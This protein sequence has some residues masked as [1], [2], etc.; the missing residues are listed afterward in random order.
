MTDDMYGAPWEL[1]HFPLARQV[2][3]MARVGFVVDT[4]TLWDQLLALSHHLSLT[5]EAPSADVLAAPVLGADETTWQL[6][7]PGRS[8][9][10]WVWAL[11]GAAGGARAGGRRERW[12]ATASRLLVDTR[13]CAS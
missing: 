9:T 1:D 2:R 5:Y 4:Q 13:R 12:R 7:E 10:W 6:V 8:K 11:C 3:Q